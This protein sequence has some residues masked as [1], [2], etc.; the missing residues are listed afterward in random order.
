MA[1]SKDCLGF[2]VLRTGTHG[3]IQINQHNA[4]CVTISNEMP[5]YLHGLYLDPPKAEHGSIVLK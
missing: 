3:D 5:Y 4:S 1:P 2:C